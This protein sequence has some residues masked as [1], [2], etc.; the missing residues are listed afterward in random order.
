[1]V[2]RIAFLPPLLCSIAQ[3]AGMSLESVVK[4]AYI[5]I[6]KDN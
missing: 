2:R 4:D 5:E 6:D 3:Q 1:M